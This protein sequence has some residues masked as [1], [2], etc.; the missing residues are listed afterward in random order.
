MLL[1]QTAFTRLSYLFD[2][3]MVSTQFYDQ[4]KMTNKCTDS[5]KNITLL[6]R[7]DNVIREINEI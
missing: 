3:R 2:F 5:L 1:I 7:H 4:L 6:L